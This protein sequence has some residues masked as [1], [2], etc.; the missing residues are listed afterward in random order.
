MPLSYTLNLQMARSVV[1]FNAAVDGIVSRVARL[2]GTRRSNFK[3]TRSCFVYTHGSAFL[4]A[5]TATHFQQRKLLSNVQ[6]KAL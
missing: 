3:K 6:V 2:E 4:A 5:T 1:R